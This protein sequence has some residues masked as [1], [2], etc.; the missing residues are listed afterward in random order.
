[1]LDDLD[2]LGNRESVRSDD[3]C[4]HPL[5]TESS[6]DGFCQ[7]VESTEAETGLSPQLI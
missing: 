6:W 7:S 1:M 2:S 5:G 4:T 3:G